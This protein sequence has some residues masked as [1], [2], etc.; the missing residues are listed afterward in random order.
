MPAIETQI[1]LVAFAMLIPLTGIMVAITPYFQPKGEVFSVSVPRSVENDPAV[2]RLKRRFSVVVL[3]A[4]AM[5]TVAAVACGFAGGESK[6]MVFI[7]S[8][9]F[10]VP[11]FVGGG[12][13]IAS[14]SRM[15]KMK[16]ERGLDRRTPSE[17]CGDRGGFDFSPKGHFA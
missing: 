2:R 3:A 16:Q 8:G 12:M 14:R 10:V 4:A 17:R 11:V 1:I 13:I 7:I 15:M 9:S 6:A 5:F